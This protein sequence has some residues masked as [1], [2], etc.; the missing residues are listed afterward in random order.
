MIWQCTCKTNTWCFTRNSK[1]ITCRCKGRVITCVL[2]ILCHVMTYPPVIRIQGEHSTHVITCCKSSRCLL[3]FYC[4]FPYGF[5]VEWLQLLVIH[6]WFPDGCLHSI[7]MSGRKHE[8]WCGSISPQSA[9]YSMNFDLAD[10]IFEL[11]RIA[12]IFF[13][14]LLHK[15]ACCFFITCHYMPLHALLSCKG[16]VMKTCSM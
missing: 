11:G 9:L 6:L 14:I 7:I 1:K 16:H 3:H 12:W 15:I 5:L 8:R 4:H 2:H 10:Q 13:Y